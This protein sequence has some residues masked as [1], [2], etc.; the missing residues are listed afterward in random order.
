[1]SVLSFLK[2][3]DL[4][5]KLL[6][7][8]T[9]TL[10]Y[11]ITKPFS[12]KEP[13]CDKPLASESEYLN[14]WQEAKN[15]RY[16]EID[17]LEI[18]LGY[19]IDLEWFS[20][21]ALITQVCIKESELCFAHGRV[22]YTVLKNYLNNSNLQSINII[23]VGTARG[24]SSLCMAKVL[25]ENKVQGRIITID[26]LPIR[27]KIFWNCILDHKGKKNRKELL[28]DYIDLVNNY[29]LF[30]KG[31]SEDILT[32]KIFD[33]IHMAFIDGVH[34]YENVSNDANYIQ[35]YQMKGDIIIFDDY[36]NN[37]F[38]GVVKAV[39]E[40][41]LRYNYS[42]KVIN[43]NENRSYAIAQKYNT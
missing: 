1:M 23:E 20:K 17:K 34:E 15:I 11:A 3:K 32:K 19:R 31:K 30:K 36:S 26:P 27:R 37:I 14:L 42:L 43:A 24:F 38:P 16:H 22:L 5:F 21:L 25:Q 28:I 4:S 39:D 8:K 9:K 10:F 13:F 12:N 6:L 41:C 2:R 33:R 29:I 7:R 40:F 35:K 18:E